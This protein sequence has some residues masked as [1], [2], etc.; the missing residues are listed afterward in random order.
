MSAVL[1][2]VRAWPE[3]SVPDPAG[4]A[5]LALALLVI[6]VLAVHQLRAGWREK[7]SPESARARV[8]GAEW[9]ALHWGTASVLVL[10]LAIVVIERVAV[11]T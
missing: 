10:V 6:V 11:L 3:R 9:L 8:W 1:E 2:V 7:A 4:A 5:G